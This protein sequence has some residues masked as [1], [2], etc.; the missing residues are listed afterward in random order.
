[1]SEGAPSLAALIEADARLAILAELAAQRD[2][3]LSA[4]VLQRVVEVVGVRRSQG[5]IE[6]QLLALADLGAVTLRN[7]EMPGFGTVSVASLTRAGRDHV[8]RRG[9][10]SGVSQP[11]DGA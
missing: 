1:M 10:I 9:R 6:T 2:A 8:E 11:G 5:W 7:A 3:T 4:L